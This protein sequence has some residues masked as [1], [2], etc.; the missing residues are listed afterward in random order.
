[1]NNLTPHLNATMQRIHNKIEKK[2]EKVSI[3]DYEMICREN[4]AMAEKLERD[5][6]TQDQISDIANGAIF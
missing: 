1:M 2:R 4:R 3:E 6:Y 5:G